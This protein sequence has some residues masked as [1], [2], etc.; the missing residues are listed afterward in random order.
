MAIFTE[1]ERMIYRITDNLSWQDAQRIGQFASADLSCE[2]FIHA[3]ER[4]Q[5]L[6]TAARYYS[7][8][9][10]LLLLEIDEAALGDT[11]KREDSIGRG[12]QFPHVYAAIPLAAVKR[13]AP[14]VE[15][16]AGFQL[17][18]DW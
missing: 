13:V 7:G 15:T 5:V 17:P 11:V 12:E 8:I 10:D 2:G 16:A 3:S 4:H 9:A 6:R 14:L 18:A 1:R